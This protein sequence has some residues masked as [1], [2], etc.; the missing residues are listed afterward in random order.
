MPTFL[1]V[2]CMTVWRCEQGHEFVWIRKGIKTRPDECAL[3]GSKD[4]DVKE[5]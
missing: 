3:C 4:I 1:E 2:V 5:V